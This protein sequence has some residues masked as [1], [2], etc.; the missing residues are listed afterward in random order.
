VRVRF[1]LAD[2]VYM[3]SFDAS[4]VRQIEDSATAMFV[5]VF[6]RHLG[7]LS[8]SND[9]ADST[10]VLYV[11]LDQKERGSRS[12]LGERGL[13]L[14]LKNPPIESGKLYWR[15]FR[16]LGF[17]ARDTVGSVTTFLGELGL[18]LDQLDDAAWRVL[19]TDLLSR[20]SIA[21][22]NAAAWAPPPGSGSLVEWLIPLRSDAACFDADRSKLLIMNQVPIPLGT[23]VRSVT[24]KP[25][26]TLTE[27]PTVVVPSRLERFR[28]Q[29]RAPLDSPATGFPAPAD[30]VQVKAVH[31]TDYKF[32][33]IGCAL[34]ARPEGGGQ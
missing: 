12:R 6:T 16:S 25:S 2:P 9:P 13:H 8:F 23:E 14:L 29:I 18:V 1:Q 21:D 20:I 31:V 17:S 10:R 11:I 19:V 30:S 4:E 32:D 3:Q 28:G 22:T 5:R 7:F 33:D 15:T 34:L 24:A 27:D 26:R